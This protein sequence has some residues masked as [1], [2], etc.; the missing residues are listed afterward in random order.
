MKTKQVS[1][2]AAASV[3]SNMLHEMARNGKLQAS[4]NKSDVEYVLNFVSNDVSAS[5]RFQ[6]MKGGLK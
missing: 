1:P 5:F 6:V 2:Q 3:I 4:E